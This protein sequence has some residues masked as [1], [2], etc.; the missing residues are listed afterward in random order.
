MIAAMFDASQGSPAKG[1]AIVLGVVAY[2]VVRWL[3]DVGRHPNVPCRPCKGT[4]VVWSRIRNAFG[5]HRAC[6]GRGYKT[7]V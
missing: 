6:G 7:R 1:G 3:I 2:F 4:G 5:E